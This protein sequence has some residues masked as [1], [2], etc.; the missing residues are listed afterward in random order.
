[1]CSLKPAGALVH[2]PVFLVATGHFS[3][4]VKSGLARFDPGQSV[5]DDTDPQPDLRPK[6]PKRSARP[7]TVG[8]S[9]AGSEVYPGRSRST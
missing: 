4:W 5:L 3:A 9:G 8:P 7:Q 1:M 6:N 2:R